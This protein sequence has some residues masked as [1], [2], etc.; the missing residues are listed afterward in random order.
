[1]RCTCSSAVKCTPRV[2]EPPLRD[3]PVSK[4]AEPP[5][6]PLRSEGGESA[7]VG[8]ELPDE[9]DVSDANDSSEAEE[10]KPS[11]LDELPDLTE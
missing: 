11:R 4:N 9:A 7:L 2:R 1:M 5:L 8:D 10:R 6:P 3:R